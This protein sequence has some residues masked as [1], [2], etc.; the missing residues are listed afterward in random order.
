MEPTIKV[1][2][3]T[4]L[5]LIT[6]ATT[7]PAWAAGGRTLPAAFPQRPLTLIVPFSAGGPVDVLGRLLAQEYSARSGQTA[8]V[9]N[10]TGG[11]G[12]I[13][14]GYRGTD[15]RLEGE[16]GYHDA[17]VGRGAEGRDRRRGSPCEPVALSDPAR[18]A[19]QKKHC[20]PASKIVPTSLNSV[21][22]GSGCASHAWALSPIVWSLSTRPVRQR[23]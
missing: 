16:A 17:G 22:S 1:T 13:E 23:R 3:R 7:V 15:W 12:N 20:W 19:V 5:A 14:L 4:A 6:Y 11:G 18:T 2:R 8:I 21:T 10:K 9:E